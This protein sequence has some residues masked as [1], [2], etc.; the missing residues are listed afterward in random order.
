MSQELVEADISTIIEACTYAIAVAIRK[1]NPDPNF[2]VYEH[3]ALHD[4]GDN[5]CLVTLYEY[6]VDPQPNNIANWRLRYGIQVFNKSQMNLIGDTNKI[7]QAISHPFETSEFGMIKA[8]GIHAVTDYYKSTQRLTNI[9]FYV[10][11][12]IRDVVVPA[13]LIGSHTLVLNVKD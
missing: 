6:D 8:K 5:G 9:V 13:E 4:I 10:N 11:L 12:R 7:I 3:D 1:G 2:E